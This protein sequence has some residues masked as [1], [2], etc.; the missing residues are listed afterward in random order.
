MSNPWK[1]IRCA[2]TI[3][4]T[5][6]Y[7][8]VATAIVVNGSRTPAASFLSLAFFLLPFLAALAA[9]G[10]ILRSA[11]V[12]AAIVLVVQVLA[13]LKVHYYKEPLLAPDF[14]V[15]ADPSNSQT[16]LRYPGA[17]AA[18]L[19]LAGVLALAFLA[20]RGAHRLGARVRYA[21][22]AGAA[23]CVAACVVIARDP[24]LH[25]AWFR[26]L[27]AGQ[28]T[29]ADLVFSAREVF[30]TPPS[31]PGDEGIFLARRP[32]SRVPAAGVKPDIIVWL[33]E[34]TVNPEIYDLPGATFPRLAMFQPDPATRAQSLLRVPTYGGGTWLSEFTLL[35]GLSARD[36]E[37]ASNAVYYGVT[38][39]LKTSLPR[40]LK[41]SGYRSV[42][43]TPFN[44]SA[45]HSGPAYED[46]G[47]DRIVQP[48]DLGYPAAPFENLWNVESRQMAG[49]A[50]QILE[51]ESG[52]V[53]LF[54]F[55]IK[56]HGPYDAGHP[57]APELLGAADRALSGRLSDYVERIEALSAAT[58]EFSSYLLG[59]KRPTL[60]LYFGDHQGVMKG[61]SLGYRISSPAP[62]Y[63]TQF[64]LR[65]N[66]PS[67]AQLPVGEV[68]DLAFIGGLLLE[69]AGV[70]PDALFGANIDMRKLCQG[71]LQ[72]CPDSPLVQ[73]YRHYVHDV[74]G[75]A[76]GQRGDSR[77]GLASP[78]ELQ[79][80]PS[81]SGMRRGPKAPSKRS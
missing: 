19:A 47:F 63:I 57:P 67:P 77:T 66:L 5:V 38:P 26:N 41:E 12:G 15:I 9:T 61:R 53:F 64:V 58:Q 44:K 35:S 6:L 46:L 20:H 68:T 34:S 40:V 45:Y 70:E 80:E 39:R 59:R 7:I 52:P 55:S 13:R 62:E 11:T 23:A 37:P 42:V 21:S 36:F 43:L 2:A 4:A 17:G 18:L 56:E 33:H 24:A 48:Q 8:V 50:R 1:R 60:F 10:Q 74:L 14:F 54:M 78:G 32:V 72:D 51:Q 30:Y 69:R 22:L 73:S 71:R 27:P 79:P 29:F 16:L 28:G 49:Y 75:A 76:S 31:F 3:A 65:D 81:T 25:D